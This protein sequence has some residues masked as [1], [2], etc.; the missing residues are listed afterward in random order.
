MGKTKGLD[1]E[2]VK[3]RSESLEVMNKELRFSG[4]KGCPKKIETNLNSSP[5]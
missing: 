2:I 4:Y 5:S 3:K 1:F